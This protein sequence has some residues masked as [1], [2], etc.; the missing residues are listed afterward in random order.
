MRFTAHLLKASHSGIASGSRTCQFC[1]VVKLCI[2]AG[3]TVGGYLFW[4]LGEKAGFDFVG[5]FLLSG[6]GSVFRV[7]AGWKFAQRFN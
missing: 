1:R 2:F 5:S 3:T 4:Y 7:Y 6:V